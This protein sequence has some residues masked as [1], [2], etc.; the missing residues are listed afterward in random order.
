M[1][2]SQS[3]FIHHLI[4]CYLSIRVVF[5]S[6][7]IPVCSTDCKT[8]WHWGE[9]L[10]LYTFVQ[11]NPFSWPTRGVFKKW[12]TT[13]NFNYSNL[14]NIFNMIFLVF[15]I[16][17]ILFFIFVMTTISYFIAIKTWN[18]KVRSF[19]KWMLILT[20]VKKKSLHIIPHCMWGC[21]L[22]VVVFYY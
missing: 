16:Q 2:R 19:R 12:S 11:C 5:T 21:L 15:I 9:T 18:S 4:T 1:N 10:P 8:L 17:Y 14:I 13:L 22:S 6:S 3:W 7:S 20:E